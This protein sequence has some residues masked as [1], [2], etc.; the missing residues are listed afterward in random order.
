MKKTVSESDNSSVW[1]RTDWTGLKNAAASVGNDAD[2]LN[3][4][5]LKYSGPLK[6]HLLSTFHGI[7]PMSD[8][9]IQDFAQDKILKTGWL[10]AADQSRGRFRDF[11]KKSLS[12]FTRDRLRKD[13]NRGTSI[14]VLDCELPTESAE[15]PFDL[16]WTRA[17]LCE[18]LSRMESHCKTP[19]K[20]Q[21][22][23]AH[24]WEVFRHRVLGP[25][26]GG[27]ARLN[28][29]DLVLRFSIASP[30][31][32][33]NMLGTA[34]RIFE[35]K[36]HEVVAEYE[37]SDRAVRA[38]IAYLKNFVHALTHAKKKKESQD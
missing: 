22:R 17:V 37:R 6:L 4:L 28:Y 18:V 8:E 10:E 36:F 5:I 3:Q 31:D 20:L 32:A 35:R 1:P 34:K 15:D 19:G 14:D 26:L 16:C 33:Q 38:E 25:E 23:L 12:N 13:S 30:T 7:G 11:L 21:P 29:E 2:R 9:I 27:E 24:I